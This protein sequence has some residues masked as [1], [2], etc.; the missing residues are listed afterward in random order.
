MD[1]VTLVPWRP[2]DA[3]RERWW[4]F[5]RPHLE[6]LGYPIF[7]GDSEGPW[8]RAAALN[9]ASRAAGEWEI[10]LVADADTVLDPTA[11]SRTLKRVRWT[12]GAARPHDHRFML[13]R[14][15]SK[16]FVQTGE[17]LPEHLGSDAP[18]GGA[19]VVHR[20]AFERVGGYDEQFVGWGYED[21]AMNIALATTSRWERIPGVS[22]HLNHGIPNF[23]S[24][25]AR[26]NRAILEG[27]RA[28]K[29]PELDRASRRA[30]YD[31]NAIL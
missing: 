30:G 21:S 14:R 18:G 1:V 6:F 10:A 11:V 31:L 5:V 9:S 2:G 26:A 27:Y 24:A 7:L 28:L 19:L 25:P 22:Y 20:E 15:A 4:A 12:R 23:L 13:N 29:A 16:K 3:N 17:I 8:A